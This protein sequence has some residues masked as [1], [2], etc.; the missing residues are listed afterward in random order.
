LDAAKTLPRIALSPLEGLIVGGIYIS[1]SGSK[2]V[3]KERTTTLV[4]ALNLSATSGTHQ[5]R[6]LFTIFIY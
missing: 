3:L 1:K 4:F 2:E 5:A 6:I